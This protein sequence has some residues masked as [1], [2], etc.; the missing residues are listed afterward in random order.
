MTGARG[1]GGK[2]STDGCHMRFLSNACAPARNIVVAVAIAWSD[3]SGALWLKLH[4]WSAHSPQN[5][6]LAHVESGVLVAWRSCRTVFPPS[7][8]SRVR[9]MLGFFAWTCAFMAVIDCGSG[10]CLDLCFYGGD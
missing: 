5:N 8:N 10:N 3:S 2:R 9:E 4:C 7:R 1:H 6:A